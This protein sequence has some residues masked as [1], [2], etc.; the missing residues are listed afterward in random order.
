M[1]VPDA[2]DQIVLQ[3]LKIKQLPVIDPTRY[4]SDI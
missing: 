3:L 4:C 2:L 1:E